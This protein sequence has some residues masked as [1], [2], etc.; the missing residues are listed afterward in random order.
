VVEVSERQLFHNRLTHTMKVSQVGRRLAELL[1]WKY[2]SQPSVLQQVGGIDPDVVEAA[3][4]AH[5][6]G[7]PPFGHIAEE[8]LQTCIERWNEKRRKLIGPRVTK[9]DDFE[10]NAQT[11]RIVTKLAVRTARSA[12]I[13]ALNLTRASLAA[14][15]KYPWMSNDERAQSKKKWGAYQSEADEFNFATTLTHPP[16]ASLE[17]SLMDWADDVTYAVHD[18]EDFI[19]S[20]HIPLA[21]L[22]SD[23]DSGEQSLFIARATERL[24]AKKQFTADEIH[25]AFS[26]LKKKWLPKPYTGA[27]ISRAEL[28]DSASSLITRYVNQ[29]EIRGQ[30]LWVGR[31]REVEV[32]VLKQ[33]TW[34]Y[35]IDNP[36]LATRQRGQRAMIADLFWRLGGWM[37]EARGDPA[38]L[39]RLPVLL[40]TCYELSLNDPGMRGWAGDDKELLGARAVVDYIAS[41][42]EEQS[43][44]LHGRLT[45]GPSQSALSRWL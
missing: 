32:N 21:A 34:C 35:V 19:R 25:Q 12:T 2:A 42:T 13:L 4:R 8:E 9:L 16:V 3:C 22:L 29:C 31:G 6:L 7:H 37:D 36:A 5:D 44:E 40:R 14:I 38:E 30:S 11:F 15:L 17:A 18:L 27:P 23:Q 43:I 33:L 41:L 10:G 20:G 1:R 28:H 39:R 26:E 45:G 24:T